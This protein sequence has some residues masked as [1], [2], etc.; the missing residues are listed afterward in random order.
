MAV[1]THYAALSGYLGEHVRA[2]AHALQAYENLLEDRAD[3]VASYLINLVLS[4]EKR[5]HQMFA[6]MQG[7][8]E[9]SIQ[10][11]E[12][13]S[14]VPSGHITG[15]L[16]ALLATTEELLRLEKADLK[17]LRQLRRTWQRAKG[18]RKL[19]A[20]LVRTAEMDT[21][22]HIHVLGYLRKLLNDA[23]RQTGSSS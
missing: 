6:D 21:K 8:L 13:K 10:W 23:S 22:K 7:T 9:R 3:D 1:P 14:H 18:E 15:D 4:D 16:D 12:V 19:W 11:R 17:S 20:L 2:E 5:H